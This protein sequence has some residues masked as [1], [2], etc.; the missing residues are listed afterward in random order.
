MA[1]HFTV[2]RPSSEQ[3]ELRTVF[4]A[5]H[6]CPEAAY[7]ERVLG[8]KGSDVLLFPVGAFGQGIPTGVPFE[9]WTTEP[10]GACGALLRAWFSWR[11]AKVIDLGAA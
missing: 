11:G 4:G 9:V 8:E 6:R 1:K 3:E 10:C 5:Q 2:D 7:K